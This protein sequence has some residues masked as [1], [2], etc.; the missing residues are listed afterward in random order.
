MLLLDAALFRKTAG[1]I[2]FYKYTVYILK[3]LLINIVLIK[4]R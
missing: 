1:V 2:V 4:A 3:I